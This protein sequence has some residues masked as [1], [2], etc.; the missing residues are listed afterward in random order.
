MRRLFAWWKCVVVGTAALAVGC[1]GESTAAVQHFR[2]VAKIIAPSADTVAIRQGE[3]VAFDGTCTDPDGDAITH[4]WEFPGGIPEA[5]AVAHPGV[6]VFDAPGTFAVSYVCR[7][8]LDTSLAV[9]RTVVVA[10]NQP[11]VAV[12]V[13]P[14]ADPAEALSGAALVFQGSCVD[15]EGGRVTHAW[16]FHGG[17]PAASTAQNA[18]SVVFSNAGKYQ[19]TYACTDAHGATT[20]VSRE[21]HVALA[22]VPVALRL[23]VDPPGVADLGVALDPAPEVRVVGSAGA[24]FARAGI[25]ISVALTGGS[26]SLTGATTRFTDAQGAARFDALAFSGSSAGTRTLEFTSPGLAG[27]SSFAIEVR[28]GL[29]AE[30]N[31]ISPLD[32]A[33]RTGEA[34]ADPPAVRLRDAFGNPVAGASVTF[35]VTAGDGTIAGSPA[36]TGTDG[37]AR[38]GSWVLGTP[39]PQAVEATATGPSAVTFTATARTAAETYDVTIWELTPLTS[40]QRA[41]FQAARGRIERVVAAD[42]ANAYVNVAPMETCGNTAIS[43]VVDDLLIL[44]SVE[45]IDGYGGVLGRAGPCLI[46]TTGS[47]PVV[48]IMRFDSADLAQMEADG[49]LG[50]VILHEMMHVLGFG[51]MWPIYG[52]VSGRGHV[53]S[54]VRRE[55]RARRVHRPQRR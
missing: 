51:T 30:M 55:P 28:A 24:D 49:Q 42:V 48:G 7:D 29:P 53:R 38:L 36:I 14:A 44:V 18:G 26:G 5:S 35:T 23:A 45:Y 39:G 10:A 4:E 11:P 12:I 52:L 19:A 17:T 33:G 27:T 21:I 50:S 6:V 37:V 25:A 47:L 32:Q 41:A 22:I 3:F 9:Q 40:G 2:P 20:A 46:R 54:R 43:G 31:A 13:S 1:S 34:V 16:T 8:A 15:P